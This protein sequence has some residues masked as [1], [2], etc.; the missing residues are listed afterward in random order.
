MRRSIAVAGTIAAGAAIAT[1]VA[2]RPLKAHWAEGTLP[3]RSGSWLNSYMNRPSYRLIAAAL[4]LTPQDDLLDVAC[5]W[6]EFL[7]VQGLQ[8]HHVAGI[9]VS[10]EK[11]LLARQR[12]ADR[13]TAGTAEVVQGDAAALPWAEDTFSAVT[14]MDAFIFF[15]DPD[16]VLA[17]V[18]RVLRP[19]GRMLMQIGMNW[20]HGL[21][22]HMP[23]PNPYGHD[24]SD[25]DAVRKML[26]EAGF[27]EISISY[28][29]VF[30]EHRLANR[31]SRMMGGSDEA[32]LVKATKPEA[33]PGR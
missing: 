15:T 19:G 12:L 24:Y 21:P 6:G 20:P 18:L 4:N 2:R 22:K 17:E 25:E 14:C 29:P 28:V 8:A 23:H 31:A 3:G 7:A 10:G 5:G 16:K 33:G 13:I 32:R 30:G 1:A 11:V 9:D 26:E 27:G